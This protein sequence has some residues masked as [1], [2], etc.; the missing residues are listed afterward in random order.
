MYYFSGNVNVI[1]LLVTKIC[2]IQCHQNLDG[3][4]DWSLCILGTLLRGGDELSSLS[5]PNHF[6]TYMFSLGWIILIFYP[7]T[8]LFEDPCYTL[9][10]CLLSHNSSKVQI[11]AIEL[12]HH[13]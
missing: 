11:E 12:V 7:F 9:T 3:A 13:H 1:L 4:H 6:P 10:C 8:T 2:M 5:S